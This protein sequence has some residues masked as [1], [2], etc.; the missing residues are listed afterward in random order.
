MPIAD[1]TQLFQTADII[2]TDAST[3]EIRAKIGNSATG[4]GYMA[5]LPMYGPDGFVG[6][7]NQPSENGASAQAFYIYDG[8]GAVIVGTRDNR[9]AEK[10]GEMAPGD[11]AIITDGEARVL[12]KREG[13]SVF[14]MT[15]NQQT[16][17]TMILEMNGADGVA[18]L[19]NGNCWFSMTGD[20]ITLSAGDSSGSAMIMLNARGIHFMGANFFCGTAGGH[21]G[22]MVPP[23][24]T[25][26]GV[27]PQEPAQSILFG[28]SGVAGAPSLSWTISP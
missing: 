1:P 19:F 23:T 26:P 17:K 27:A 22:Y 16:G 8:D 3:G 2:E 15:E 12:I 21:F 13:D 20:T 25:S 4:L 6:R 5:E 10:V 28:P 11:R 14:I 24:A 9:Y 18:Q 7:P